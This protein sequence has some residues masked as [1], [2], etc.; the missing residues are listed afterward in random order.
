MFRS[1]EGCPCGPGPEGALVARA[2]SMLRATLLLVS[3]LWGPGEQ[4]KRP[5]SSPAL[6]H[7]MPLTRGR[8]LSIG[9][10]SGDGV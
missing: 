3:L 9:D 10:A 7:P 2:P 6:G 8:Y 5:V 1:G 4:P